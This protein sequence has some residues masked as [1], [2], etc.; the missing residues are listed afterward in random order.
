MNEHKEY[1]IAIIG[2]GINDYYFDDEIKAIVFA[3]ENTPSGKH[4]F[5]LRHIIDCIYDV[6]AQIK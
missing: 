4:S 5:L 1:R 3:V 6:V 2:N